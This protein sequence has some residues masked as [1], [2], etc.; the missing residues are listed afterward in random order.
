MCGVEPMRDKTRNFQR[1][2]LRDIRKLLKLQ[3]ATIDCSL[4]WKTLGHLWI[5]YWLGLGTCEYINRWHRQAQKMIVSQRPRT[6]YPGILKKQTIEGKVKSTAP[7]NKLNLMD[8]SFLHK[9]VLLLNLV[10]KEK[11]METDLKRFRMQSKIW[12]GRNICGK[13][14]W[15]IRLLIEDPKN[16]RI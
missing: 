13:P 16:L 14:Y 2:T 3:N 6:L 11:Q 7:R 1:C 15:Y 4:G 12:V 5:N 9:A 10:P 8:E